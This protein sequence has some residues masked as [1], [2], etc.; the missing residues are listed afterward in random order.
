MN[1]YNS[2]DLISDIENNKLNNRPAYY[3]TFKRNILAKGT[4]NEKCDET[5]LFKK[6]PCNNLKFCN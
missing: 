4:M 1:K 3:K 6:E 5:K 2:K